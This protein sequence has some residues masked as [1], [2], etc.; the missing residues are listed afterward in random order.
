VTLRSAVVRPPVL[1][2]LDTC[3]K[4]R[5]VIVPGLVQHVVEALIGGPPVGATVESLLGDELLLLP[6]FQTGVVMEPWE[7][8]PEQTQPR[9]P[10]PTVGV[11]VAREESRRL[12]RL[13]DERKHE[14]AD[15]QRSQRS[16]HRIDAMTGRDGRQR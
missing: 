3:Q 12:S 6:R 5:E 11:A 7:D 16:S 10:A 15:D 4:H 9:L 8:P 1:R 14:V 13:A 2:R